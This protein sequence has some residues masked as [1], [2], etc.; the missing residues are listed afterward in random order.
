M[1]DEALS[2]EHCGGHD[3]DV[4]DLLKM[5][6]GHLGPYVMAGYRLGRAALTRLGAN[7]YFRIRAEVWCPDR[8]PPSCALDGIQLATGCTLG[9]QNIHHHP[10]PEGVV[11]R[12]TNLENGQ[13]VTLRLRQEAM[14][15]AEAAMREC[16]D[17]GGVTALQSLS[18]DQLLQQV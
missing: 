1:G 11:L 4:E 7:K 12:L 2:C 8:P 17:E 10:A 3:Y 15:A 5:F 6:H 13:Q 18:D 14:A 9:K 16:G